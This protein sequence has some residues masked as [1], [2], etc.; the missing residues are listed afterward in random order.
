MTLEF[1]IDQE[2]GVIF[3]TAGGDVTRADVN[4]N[5]TRI[6]E[7]PDFEHGRFDHLVDYRRARLHGTGDELMESAKWFREQN[8]VKRLAL[9][10]EK[11][12]G[13]ARLTQGWLGGDEV[14]VRAF[15]TTPSVWRIARPHGR[16]DLLKQFFEHRAAERGQAFAPAGGESPEPERLLLAQAPLGHSFAAESESNGRA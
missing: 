9:V 1:R 5:R 7:H 15:S 12:S 4:E 8:F 11:T 13:L 6:M 2:A 10:G 3:T 16:D 14:R